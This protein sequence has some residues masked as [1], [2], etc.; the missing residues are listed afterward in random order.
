MIF[1]RIKSHIEKENWFAVFID[2][3]IVVI[4]VFI[5]I[6]VANWND[7]ATERADERQVLTQMHSDVSA[8]VTQK[9][10]WLTD[11]EGHRVLLLE[12]I[13][14]IQ[15]KPGQK[16][17]NDPHCEAMWSSHLIFYPVAP[18]GSL[19]EI[20]AKGRL[21][22]PQGLLV[23]PSLLRF[24][25]HYEVIKQ[26][27]SSMVGLANLGDSYSDAFPRRVIAEPDIT[28]TENAQEGE[29]VAR[30]T[31]S[32]FK[33]S[34]VPNVIRANQTIQNKLLSN[35]ARTDG[36]LQR[37]RIELSALQQIQ[38]KLEDTAP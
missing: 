24:R 36:V 14:I 12:A 27:N 16:T 38:S 31:D 37:V 8:A 35:L 15:N 21:V 29:K 19:D 28:R 11:M 10:Q 23:R 6:Q 26:L 32:T 22:T 33:T 34:C 30:I 25:D 2:F 4:G 5:G 7:V 9:T 20:L 3:A 18:L 13:N 17:I 1:R